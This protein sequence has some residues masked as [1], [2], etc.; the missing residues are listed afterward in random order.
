MNHNIFDYFF[1]RAFKQYIEKE[2]SYGAYF[3]AALYV[4]VVFI[5]TTSF[6]SLN[7]I[8]IIF[9]QKKLLIYVFIILYCI[10]IATYFVLRYKKYDQRK[11][12][13]ELFHRYGTSIFNKYIPDWSI[14]LIG[15]ILCPAGGF[16]MVWVQKNLLCYL[17]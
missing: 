17:L 12:R 1:Y 7:L 9:L 4:S 10:S 5:C 16:F 15:I 8:K 6:I 13:I 3:N 2:G 11:N 14:W